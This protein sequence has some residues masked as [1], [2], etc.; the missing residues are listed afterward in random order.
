MYGALTLRLSPTL[1]VSAAC[2]P[3]VQPSAI[4]TAI[5]ATVAAIL[6]L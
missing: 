6:L 4:V 1:I 5:A 3:A 2:A